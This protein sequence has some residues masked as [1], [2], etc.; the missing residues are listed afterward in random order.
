MLMTEGK[1][2]TMTRDKLTEHGEKLLAIVRSWRGEFMTRSDIAKAMDKNKVNEWDV[3]LL[4]DL[5]GQGYIEI[6]KRPIKSPI[7]YEWVYRT[8]QG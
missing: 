1:G 5:A 7:G 4:N 2:V 3:K 6:M 8:K